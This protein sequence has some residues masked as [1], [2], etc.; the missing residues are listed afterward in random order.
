M[1]SMSTK[2]DDVAH[3]D[4]LSN[5]FTSLLPCMSIATLTFDL[6]NQ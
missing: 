3:S 4:L 5:M 6:Q 1:A 2:F